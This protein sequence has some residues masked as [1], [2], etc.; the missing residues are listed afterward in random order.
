[1]RHETEINA[2]HHQNSVFHAMTKYI[3]WTEFDRLVDDHKADYRVRSLKTKDQFLA[4]LFSQL[5]GCSSLREIE[6]GL[7]SYE[8]RLYHLGTTVPARSTLAD[9][10]AKRPWQVYGDLFTFMVGEANRKVRR[11]MGEITRIIDSTSI[12]L[13]SLSADWVKLAQGHYAGKVHIVYD[14]DR[15]MPLKAEVT[16]CTINDITPA[17]ALTLEAGATYV[18]DLGYYD[19][20]WWSEMDKL[21]CRFVTRLKSNTHLKDTTELTVPAEAKTIISDRIGLLPRRMKASRRNPMWDPVREITVRIAT[22]KI[23]R[24]VTNDLDA[25]VQEIADL[26]KRRWQIELLFKWLKQNLEIKH[27]LGTSQN[28]VYIQ[29]FVA[30]ISYLLLNLARQTQS[31]VHSAK[32][33]A[34]L[35]CINIMNRRPIEDLHREYRPPTADP[36]Q[37]AMELSL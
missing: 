37:M 36:R 26:Y 9:A 1:M 6:A 27:F 2:M 15:D 14:P 8:S 30:L 28:A 23:I 22:G 20:G 29:V 24:I 21:G 33:F 18:F 7:A 16:P 19:Y 17:K 34:N 3:P 13:S 25:P 10:N 32:R 31:S 4:L 11:S 35:V 12:S 5:S